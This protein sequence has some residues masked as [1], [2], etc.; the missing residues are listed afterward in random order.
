LTLCLFNRNSRRR[1]VKYIN[2]LA[3]DFLLSEKRGIAAAERSFTRAVGRH[4][5]PETI[6]LGGHPAAH[7]AVA[8]LKK[9]GVLR[10][11]TKVWASRHLNNLV[12]QDHRRAKQRLHPMLG[13]ESFRNAAE[14]VSGVELAQQSRKGQ[15]DTPALTVREGTIVPHAWEAVLSA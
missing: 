6:T 5:T 11:G 8:E 14:T 2:A 7:A 15:Y 9:G 4:V 1:G 13:F 10:P 3:V 12:E